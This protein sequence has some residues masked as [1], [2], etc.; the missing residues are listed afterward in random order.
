MRMMKLLKSNNIPVGMQ[1]Q[2][3]NDNFNNL[4][5]K[6]MSSKVGIPGGAAALLQVPKKKE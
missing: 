6:T 1:L 2:S 3:V 5:S 4:I